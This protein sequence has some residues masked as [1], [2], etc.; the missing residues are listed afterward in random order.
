MK[1]R[2]KI[3]SFFLAVVTLFLFLSVGNVF[4]KENSSLLSSYQQVY[5]NGYSV[6]K[7]KDFMKFFDL[8]GQVIEKL[9]GVDIVSKKTKI[10]LYQIQL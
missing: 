6:P 2:Y 1:I 4:A 8:M 10:T 5:N 3:I 9:T 7:T